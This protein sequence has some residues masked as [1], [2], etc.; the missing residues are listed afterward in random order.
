MMVHSVVIFIGLSVIIFFSFII[1]VD[2]YAHINVQESVH[3]YVCMYE[4]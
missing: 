2:G 3:V 4:R 1:H